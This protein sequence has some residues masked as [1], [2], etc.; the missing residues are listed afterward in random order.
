MQQSLSPRLGRKLGY[1]AAVAMV[2]RQPPTSKKDLQR[3]RGVAQYN[4]LKLKQLLFYLD[5]D[6]N[7]PATVSD[8]RETKGAKERKVE[9]STGE[10]G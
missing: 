8:R 1:A 2:S 4:E 9:A 10:R 7:Y 3:S 6:F 5:V